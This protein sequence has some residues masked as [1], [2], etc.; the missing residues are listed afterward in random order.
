MNIQFLF[1]SRACFALANFTSAKTRQ[2]S[3]S[4]LNFNR[5]MTNSYSTT[6][7]K[8]R[9]ES[10]ANFA[11][12]S[13]ELFSFS[14]LLR[15]VVS[16]M[17]KDVAFP[18][19]FCPR[20][21]SMLWW[22]WIFYANSRQSMK[23]ETS[24]S[25]DAIIHELVSLTKLVS[26]PID[27]WINDFPERSQERENCL[28]DVNC[29]WGKRKIYSVAIWDRQRRSDILLLRN[30]SFFDLARFFLEESREIWGKLWGLQ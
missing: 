6:D 28:I 3:S 29:R 13:D 5:K 19:P 8:N 21:L 23:L 4:A 24:K 11:R 18:L 14:S 12:K 9:N 25:V 10:N 16:F 26:L 15:H 30:F 2:N 20:P 27:S 1:L 17:L 7:N 22:N